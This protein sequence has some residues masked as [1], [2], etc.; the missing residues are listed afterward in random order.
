MRNRP[1]FLLGGWLLFLSLC[2][3]GCHAAEKKAPPPPSSPPPTSVP[4]SEPSPPSPKQQPESQAAASTPI[5]DDIPG[6]TKNL[7]I[8]ARAVNGTKIPPG[9]IFSFNASVGKRTKEKGYQEAIGYD[10]NGRKKPTIGGGICQISSTIYMA[11]L[12]G[13]YEV[14][15]RHSHSH[16]VPYADSAHDATVSYGGYDFC[17]RNNRDKPVEIRV[18][19][20]ETEVTAEILEQEP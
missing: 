12:A 11:A 9:E 5:C 2:I 6:R 4:T 14:T 19:V 10:E 8:A 20:S 1:C 3:A 16:K 7:I 17:F 18:R 13:S 15:E